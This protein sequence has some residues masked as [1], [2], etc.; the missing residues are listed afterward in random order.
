MIHEDKHV[1]MGQ[2]YKDGVKY[3]LD[4]ENDDSTNPVVGWS[5]WPDMDLENLTWWVGLLTDPSKEWVPHYAADGSLEKIT[6]TVHKDKFNNYYNVEVDHIQ[7]F[8]FVKADPAKI[9][10]I[11]GQENVN[12]SR[13]FSWE[14]DQKNMKALDVAFVNTSAQPVSNASEA[15][16]RA[17]A[18]CTVEHDKII[19][20]R[21]EEAGMWK[22]E[23]Q[24]LYGYQGYQFVYLDDNGITLMVSGAGSKVPE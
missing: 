1:K 9:A 16:A 22:V 10:E 3:R 15:I 24:I 11:I 13:T 6:C 18:E 4:H 20:Y 8:E 12:T 5:Q 21:D 2:M 14:D 17:M 23:F 7:V 19:V